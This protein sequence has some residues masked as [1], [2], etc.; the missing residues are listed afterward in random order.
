MS[1]VY[2]IGEDEAGKKYALDFSK[3]NNVPYLNDGSELLQDHVALHFTDDIVSLVQRDG[4]KF[5][6]VN[7]SF[8]E[9][10]AAHRRQY[11]GGKGQMIAKAV[12]LSSKNIPSVF[13]ATAGLGRDAFVLATLGCKVTMMER[14][15]VVRALL[16]NGLKHAEHDAIEQDDKELLDILMRMELCEGNSAHEMQ[17]LI[18]DKKCYDV[19]YL[20]PMFPERKKSALVKKEMRMFHYVVG[21]DEDADF[22]LEAAIALAEYRV[23]VKRPKQAPFLDGRAP[24]YQLKG[25]SSRFDIY[26][27]KAFSV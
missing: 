17:N 6:K 9:G 18:E 25:K 2:A 13:D 8:S 4:K 27:N 14:S 16:A 22:L 26:A 12:G 23:V 11:G 5:V 10:G 24:S 20:D 1:K 3:T 19:V 21:E 7:A 15:P